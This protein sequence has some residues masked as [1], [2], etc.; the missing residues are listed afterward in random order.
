MS[1]KEDTSQGSHRQI[2]KSTTLVGGSQV[3][4]IIIGIVR[5]KFMAILLG[6]A[7]VGLMGIY[8]SAI[9]M[10]GTI[11]G[12][13]IGSSGVRQIAEAAGSGDDKKIARTIYA[14]RRTAIILGFLGMG[15]TIALS[16][17][18]SLVTFGTK[19]HAWAFSLLAVTILFRS[20]SG[21]QSALIQGMRRIG[22]LAKISVIGAFLGTALSVP[23]VYLWREDGIVPSLIVVSA[24]S[25]LPSWLYARKIQVTRV[26][27]SL[28]DVSREMRGLLVLG[29]V[30]M[31]S[32]VMTTGVDYF[33]RV[34]VG[35]ELGMESVGLYQCANTLSS[36]YIGV[37]LNAMGMDFYPRLTAVAEDNET[38][39]RLVN[40]QTEVGL[41]LATPGILATL[42]FA[43]YLIQLFYSAKF[44]PAYEV[45]RWQILGIFLRVIAWPMGFILLAKGKSKAFFWTELIWNGMHAVLVW[46]GVKLFGLVGTGM[47]FFGLYVTYTIGIYWVVRGITGF[48]WEGRNMTSGCFLLGS[49]IILFT[50]SYVV[51]ETG[52]IWVAIILLGGT[53][54]YCFHN[55]YVILGRAWFYT[56]AE[57]AVDQVGKLFPRSGV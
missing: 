9:G 40:E 31:A 14:L 26:F 51:G 33:I 30:F 34:Y 43:P 17:Q 16:K 6:P 48:K 29:S 53:T 49:I 46:G 12:L 3:I 50:S 1:V 11:T 44:V 28:R 5:T 20:V 2:L 56:I 10:V 35:R 47:A 15:V 45:L 52:A 41:L 57:K 37:I 39:N 7:G 25:I 27:M 38:V 22:D 21:G 23:I 19:E 42:A 13:G 4:N 32:G 18:L 36:L 8:Q 24:M 54:F 55:L